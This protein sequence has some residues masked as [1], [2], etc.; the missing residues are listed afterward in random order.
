M[1]M[2]SGNKQFKQKCLCSLII[3][4]IYIVGQNIPA[5]WV[6]IM[7]A[8]EV[9]SGIFENIRSVIGSSSRIV[10]LFYMG[11]MPWMTSSILLPVVNL[12]ALEE[13]APFQFGHEADDAHHRRGLLC[14]Y[15][16]DADGQHAV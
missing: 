6:K 9:G 13:K 15:D 11:I 14:S 2:K 12:L 4:L 5:P 7:P 10:S 16:M 1:H 3:I 8:E